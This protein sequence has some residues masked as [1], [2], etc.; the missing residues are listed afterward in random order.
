MKHEAAAAGARSRSGRVAQEMK[1]VGEEQ[2]RGEREG[3]VAEEEEDQPFPWFPFLLN[4]LHIPFHTGT[5]YG[6]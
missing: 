3:E 2:V 5:T 1:M 6:S 4:A